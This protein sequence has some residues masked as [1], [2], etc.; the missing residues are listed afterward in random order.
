MSDLPLVTI[1]AAQSLNGMIAGKFGRHVDISG[2]TD[3]ERVLELRKKSDAVLVGASTVINDNPDLGVGDAYAKRRPARIVLD[4]RLSVPTHSRVFDGGARTIVLT[5]NRV[6]KMNNC[7]MV[8]FNKALIPPVEI[9]RSLREL[10]I[11]SVLV[12]G[13]S[14]VIT[15][16]VLSGLVDEFYLYVG[17]ILIE[18][19]GV[20]MFSPM[21]NLQDPVIG[22]RILGDGVLYTLDVGKLR[23]GLENVI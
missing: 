20:R 19:D 17:N 4:G 18:N 1:N 10:G 2:K 21:L 13:G 16:F 6:R 7:E 9:L 22:A 15:Q 8:Y 11:N 23:E 5:A 3:R 12:E 14:K